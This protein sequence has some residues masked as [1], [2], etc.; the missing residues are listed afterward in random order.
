MQSLVDGVQRAL[1]VLLAVMIVYVSWVIGLCFHTSA[2]LN[3]MVP[4]LMHLML[5]LFIVN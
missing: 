5:S 1:D 3:L 4:M 2:C